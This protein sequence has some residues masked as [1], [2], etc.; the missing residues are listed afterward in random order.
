MVSIMCGWRLWRGRRGSGC[1]SQLV[2]S[3]VC[4]CVARPRV[5]EAFKRAKSETSESPVWNRGRDRFAPEL[6]GSW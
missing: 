4:G 2:L 1:L 5:V 3:I 6:E